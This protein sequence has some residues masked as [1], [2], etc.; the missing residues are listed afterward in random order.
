MSERAFDLYVSYAPEDY[1]KVRRIVEE[2]EWIGLQV[3]FRDQPQASEDSVRLLQTALGQSRAH[4]VVWSKDSAA[5]GRVQ[6]EARTSAEQGRLIASR[7]DM[8]LPP[9]G[10]KAI[11]YAD[12]IDWE[13]GQ[14][15]RGMK[16]LLNAVYQ[17]TGKGVAPT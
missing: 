6:A 1:D 11:T 8:V 15:H 10:T 12:L 3:W 17:L 5:S 13:G 16:K 2:L 9:R 4:L 7:I 14:D